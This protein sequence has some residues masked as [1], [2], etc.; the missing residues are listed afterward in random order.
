MWPDVSIY[1]GYVKYLHVGAFYSS[2]T[3]CL[4][5]LSFTLKMDTAG[6]STVLDLSTELCGVTFKKPFSLKVN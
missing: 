2:S 3:S 1:G 4:H 5:P 6:S